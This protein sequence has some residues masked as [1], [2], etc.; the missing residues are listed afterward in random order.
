MQLHVLNDTYKKGALTGACSYDSPLPIP[1]SPHL[2]LCAT[3]AVESIKVKL[4]VRVVT[5]EPVTARMS[6]SA[7]PGLVV[8][9]KRTVIEVELVVD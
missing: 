2:I 1:P 5:V 3:G 9:C 6:K 7:G 8:G 4:E